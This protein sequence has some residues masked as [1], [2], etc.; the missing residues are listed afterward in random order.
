M[1]ALP[2]GAF[3]ADVDPE[4]GAPRIRFSF[5]NGWSAH[6]A[7]DL[8]VGHGRL[9]RASIS[10]APTGQWGPTKTEVIAMYVSADDAISSLFFIASREKPIGGAS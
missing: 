2:S 9:L 6:L 10:A 5:E 1:S 7:L 3:E 4:T 8:A